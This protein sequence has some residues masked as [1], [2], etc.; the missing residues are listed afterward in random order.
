MRNRQKKALRDAHRGLKKIPKSLFP[1]TYMAVQQL[2][3]SGPTLPS[4]CRIEEQL[5]Y[6]AEPKEKSLKHQPQAPSCQDP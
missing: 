4:E 6:S 5:Q 3:P 1:Y 2:T